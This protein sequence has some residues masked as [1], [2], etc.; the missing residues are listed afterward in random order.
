MNNLKCYITSKSIGNMYFRVMEKYVSFL[1]YVI[2][3]ND[4][5]SD[6]ACQSLSRC[7][8][9]KHQILQSFLDHIVE[10][11][12][13]W[14]STC[15]RTKKMSLIMMEAVSLTWLSLEHQ[16]LSIT[17][18]RKWNEQGEG[19]AELAVVVTEECRNF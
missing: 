13:L 11:P 19:R 8:Q 3:L 10:P 4:L 17:R 16:Q 14:Q 15:P 12:F 1:K 6:S 9:Q 2:L 7:A 5:P 18:R